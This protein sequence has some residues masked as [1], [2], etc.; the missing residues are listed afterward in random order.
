MV[1]LE[2]LSTESDA[3]VIA[4]GAVAFDSTNILSEFE[5]LIDPVKT[6]G[7]RSALTLEWWAKQDRE[8]RERMFSGKASPSEGYF[9]FLNWADSQN[10]KFIW[11][12]DPQFDVAILRNLRKWVQSQ[13]GSSKVEFPFHFRSERSFRTITWIAKMCELD[14]S[15]A[16][17]DNVAHDALSDAKAQARAV[18]VIAHKLG[19]KL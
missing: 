16:Y 5:V 10:L 14:Y 6:P 8:V 3:A 19:L 18:Q 17:A 2:T 12:N 4:I 11:G 1:D 13:G 9:A 15:E 7:H